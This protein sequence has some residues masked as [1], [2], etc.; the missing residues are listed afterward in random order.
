[1]D[2]VGARFSASRRRVEQDEHDG[3]AMTLHIVSADERLAEAN[4]KTTVAIFG[5]AGAGKTSLLRTLLASTALC[6][7][8]DAGLKSVQDWQGDK[9]FNRAKEQK[10]QLASQTLVGSRR[11]L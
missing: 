4:S 6:V 2:G 10:R 7:D 9:G 5:P 3:A 11:R 1:M 8:L